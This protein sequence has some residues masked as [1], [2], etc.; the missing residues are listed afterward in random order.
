[1][2]WGVACTEKNVSSIGGPQALASIMEDWWMHGCSPWIS[3]ARRR[4]FG[5]FFLQTRLFT[6][7]VVVFLAFSVVDQTH[8]GRAC[9]SCFRGSTSHVGF[10]PS[11]CEWDNRSGWR[12][13]CIPGG[14]GIDGWGVLDRI[15]IERSLFLSPSPS[16]ETRSIR[17]PKDRRN[18]KKQHT[19]FR[20]R[21]TCKC[22]ERI[23]RTWKSEVT[24]SLH[25]P[26][27]PN[28]RWKG[29]SKTTQF[30]FGSIGSTAHIPT[31]H[32]DHHQG[33]T[34]A[35]RSCGILPALVSAT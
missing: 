29:R 26:R 9:F 6:Q 7:H 15:S 2:A 8:I 23:R 24:G 22:T 28:P 10:V 18:D 35:F 33:T 4:G 30:C 3:M 13:C 34:N 1:M 27:P 21:H 17:D 19:F 31:R 16:K 14:D 20:Q 25:L 12:G 32:E 11:V 5:C